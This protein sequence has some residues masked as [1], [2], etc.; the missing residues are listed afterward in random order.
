MQ[1]RG[2][3][4]L[5]ASMGPGLFSPED[6]LE[7]LAGA[8]DVVGRTPIG[9]DLELRQRRHRAKAVVTEPTEEGCIPSDQ[10]VE[11]PRDGHSQAGPRSIE[12]RHE[13][14]PLIAA[15]ATKGESGSPQVA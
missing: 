10:R 11:C 14:P 5:I 9:D 12:G 1:V 3:R 6:E 15:A 4:L 7:D 13:N 2:F 8:A